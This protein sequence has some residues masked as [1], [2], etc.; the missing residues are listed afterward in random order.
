MKIIRMKQQVHSHPNQNS[1]SLET[2]ELLYR[3]IICHI[4][5]YISVKTPAYLR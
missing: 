3:S 1:M 5:S 2:I 4:L